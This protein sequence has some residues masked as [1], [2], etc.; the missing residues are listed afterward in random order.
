[1]AWNLGSGLE[2]MGVVVTGATGGIGSETVRAFEAAGAHVCATDLRQDALDDLLEGLAHPERHIA[3]AADLSRRDSHAELLA[4]SVKAFGR[5][6][7]LAHVAAVLR[8]RSTV[9][10]ITEDDWD[11]QLGVNLKSSFFLNMAA[12]ELFREQGRGGRIINLVSTSWW[13]GGT[14]VAIPYASSKGGLVSMS[15]SLARTFAPDNITVNTVAPGGVDTAMM[16][17]DLSQEQ[18]DAYV[19]TVPI[20]RLAHPGE[21]ASAIVFL[22]SAHASYITGTTLNVSGGQLLY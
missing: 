8:R 21:I 22:A 13:T 20:G 12:G 11:L 7:V 9:A 1:M 2:G 5:V 17:S 19:A 10:E 16:R 14:S 3:V 18:L 6:G 4:Q 15:R